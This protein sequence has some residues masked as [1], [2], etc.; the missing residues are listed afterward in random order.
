MPDHHSAEREH[1]SPTR[2]VILDALTRQALAHRY[3][4]IR[5]SDIIE[6]AG[7]GRSTFYEHFRSKNDVL[8]T[9]LEPI[10]LALAT[11]ASGR[12]ARSYIRQAVDHLWERRSIGRALLGSSAAPLIQR[13][14]ADGIRLRIQ[15]SGGTDGASALATT[16]VAAAQ[17]AMLRSWLTGEASATAD[18][19]TDR[20]IACSKL[21][22]P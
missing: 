16:G 17:L 15:R 11:A 7:V 8:L 2:A 21:A 20:L 12:A 14:L 19:M 9:A 4:A 1:A 13:R 18:E 5:V 22:R 6:A 3:D 10:L